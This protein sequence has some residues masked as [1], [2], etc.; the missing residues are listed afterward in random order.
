MTDT[1]TP[2]AQRRSRLTLVGCGNAKVDL[3]DREAET[4]PAA[5]LYS[6]SY[7]RLKREYAERQS[8]SWLILSALHGLLSPWEPIESYDVSLTRSGFSGRDEPRYASIDHWATAVDLDLCDVIEALFPDLDELVVLA[9]QAYVEPLRPALEAICDR[10]D[11]TL[12]LPFDQTSGIGEQ[13][14]W[15]KEHTDR[16]RSVSQQYRRVF[17]DEMRGSNR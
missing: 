5:K 6:S 7:F 1:R 12:W 9:G 13:M 3:S 10:H 16:S 2:T 8:D 17:A 4:I 14:A 11:V 15:L